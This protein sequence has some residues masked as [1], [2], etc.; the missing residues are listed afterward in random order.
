MIDHVAFVNGV[1]LRVPVMIPPVAVYVRFEASAATGVT[2][3]QAAIAMINRIFGRRIFIKDYPLKTAPVETSLN[4]TIPPI[5][6]TPRP[7]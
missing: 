5:V 6:A 7:E 3:M 2:R 4:L 1:P